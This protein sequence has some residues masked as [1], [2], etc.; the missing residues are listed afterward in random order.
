MTAATIAKMPPRRSSHRRR[1]ARRGPTGPSARS[2]PR[3]TKQGAWRTPA[4]NTA[5]RAPDGYLACAAPR[6]LDRTLARLPSDP[7]IRDE[8]KVVRRHERL[9]RARHLHAADLDAP[10]VV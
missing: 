9:A 1:C 4:P 2:R 5:T 7:E 6:T 8:R 10:L 3:P